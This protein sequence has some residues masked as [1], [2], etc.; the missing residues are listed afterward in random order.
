M[1]NQNR[2]QAI[3]KIKILFQNKREIMLQKQQNLEITTEKKGI[4][5][6]AIT[7]GLQ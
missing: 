5:E 7:T 6:T 1:L 3:I 4:E 2:K